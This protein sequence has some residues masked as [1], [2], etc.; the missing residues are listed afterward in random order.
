[1]YTRQESWTRI[2]KHDIFDFRAVD[3]MLQFIYSGEYKLDP[4]APWKS[5]TDVKITSRGADTRDENE[6]PLIAHI[7]VYGIAD[8]YEVPELKTLARENFK[9]AKDAFKAPTT[10][11]ILDLATVMYENTSI[12]AT[13]LRAQLMDL[14]YRNAK[15]T[16]NNQVF[17]KTIA[18]RSGLQ[19]F[20]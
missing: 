16:I 6:D 17:L 18:Q 1:M 11:T 10:Q 5:M 4:G 12:E 13:E 15:V 2:I 20:R 9:V 3:R 19:E 7:Y 8:Y 14:C